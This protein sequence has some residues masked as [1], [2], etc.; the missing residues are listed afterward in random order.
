MALGLAF[1]GF[2][3]DPPGDKSFFPSERHWSSGSIGGDG[4]I[5]GG[6][7]EEDGGFGLHACGV[8]LI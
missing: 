3:D 1:K 2:L 6:S 8:Q 4:I 5:G 7:Y